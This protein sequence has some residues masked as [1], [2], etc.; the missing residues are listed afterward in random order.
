LGPSKPTAE[1]VIAKA[2][3]MSGMELTTALSV[4]VFA[5]VVPFSFAGY[6]LFSA[7]HSPGVREF[8]IAMLLALFTFTVV[9]TF[10]MIFLQGLGRLTLPDKLLHWLGAATLGQVSGLV[11]L[12]VKAVL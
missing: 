5:L 9:A 10:G 12:V 3:L 4:I 7:Q 2:K 11:Y 8:T 1:K 6:F